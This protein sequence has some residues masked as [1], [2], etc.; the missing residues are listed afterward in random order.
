MLH[1]LHRRSQTAG[2]IKALWISNAVVHRLLQRLLKA[3][4]AVSLYK[5]RRYLRDIF[6]LYIVIAL[7]A[8]RQIKALI[9]AIQ[10]ALFR[11]YAMRRGS[12]SSDDARLGEQRLEEGPAVTSCA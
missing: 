7:A 3:C 2:L 8:G 1:Q 6:G 4:L 10:A 12:P 11:A 5:Y 9:A